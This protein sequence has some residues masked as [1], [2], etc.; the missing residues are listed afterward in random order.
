[1]G[2]KY[3]GLIPV[4]AGAC[5]KPWRYKFSSSS[6]HVDPKARS[7][8]LNLSHWYDMI[9]AEQ[10]RKEL[11][12][13][14]TDSDVGRLRLNTHTGR[15]LGSDGFLSKLEKKLGRRVRPLPA[16][17]PKKVKKRKTLKSRK[18]GDN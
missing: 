7:D 10:W 15:P 2:M 12:D 14:L 4:R 11:A 18:I 9:T 17:R 6:V 8:L 3:I 13:G 1:M 5:R 16:G